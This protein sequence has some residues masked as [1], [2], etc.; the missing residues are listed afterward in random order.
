MLAA[1]ECA[2]RLCAVVVTV[3]VPVGSRQAGERVQR[4]ADDYVCLA[5]PEPFEAVGEWY[6]DFRQTTD[7]EVRDLLE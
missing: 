6:L 7:E 4:V 5:T 2:K 1:I 3:A